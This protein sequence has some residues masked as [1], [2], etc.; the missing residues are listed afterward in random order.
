LLQS[1]QPAILL[2]HV[3][4]PSL[5]LLSQMPR[6]DRDDRVVVLEIVRKVSE[7]VDKAD[8]KRPP[9]RVSIRLAGY[10][11]GR[12]VGLT[13]RPRSQS[14]QNSILSATSRYR[15][16]TRRPSL[17]ASS[18]PTKPTKKNASQVG[19]VPFLDFFRSKSLLTLVI[20]RRGAI[21]C[22]FGSTGGFLTCTR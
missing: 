22:R 15:Q 8:N 5:A 2:T 20:G 6:S 16:R 1:L 21:R 13:A 11:S 10:D 9:R 19:Q 4:H 12:N 3:V 18:P 17:R 14:W 7:K